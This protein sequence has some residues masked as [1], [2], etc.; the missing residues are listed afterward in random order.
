MQL[1]RHMYN[2]HACQASRF[3]TTH[4]KNRLVETNKKFV[5]FKVNG[6]VSTIN[7][8]VKISNPSLLS[9]IPIES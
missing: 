2:C 6:Y 9:F 4:S 8:S 7:H 3:S 1:S 5:K